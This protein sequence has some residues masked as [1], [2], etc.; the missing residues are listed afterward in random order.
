MNSLTNDIII[1]ILITQGQ[2]GFFSLLI[3]CRQCLPVESTI[4]N[5]FKENGGG[6]SKSQSSLSLMIV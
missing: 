2:Y 6:L 4:T 1:I 3:F 5:I